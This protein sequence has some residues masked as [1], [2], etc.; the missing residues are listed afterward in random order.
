MVAGLKPQPAFAGRP[1]QAN[2]TGPEK[3]VAPVMLMGAL[4][5]CPALTV[6]VVLPL[7]SGARVNAALISWLSDEEEACV[8]VSPE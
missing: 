7:P 8:F 2:V 5:V 3:P 4:T 1:E 6:K